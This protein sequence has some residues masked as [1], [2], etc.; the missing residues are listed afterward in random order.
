MQAPS[1]RKRWLLA[2]TLALILGLPMCFEQ[3]WYLGG[4]TATVLVFLNLPGMLLGLAWGGRYFPPEGIIGQ[5][6]IRF[7]LMILVQSVFWY[8]II[9]LFAFLARRFRSRSRM[10]V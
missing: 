8:L 10:K 2:F 1:H 9:S 5:S 3:T 6:P 4:P 7:A